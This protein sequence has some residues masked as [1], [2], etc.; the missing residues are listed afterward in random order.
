[1][2]VAICFAAKARFE[3]QESHTSPDQIL[4]LTIY[5]TNTSGQVK[6]PAADKALGLTIVEL[7]TGKQFGR[8]KL[9]KTEHDV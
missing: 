5:V 9:K 3:G 4:E 1:M 8:P 2:V 7:L 6:S